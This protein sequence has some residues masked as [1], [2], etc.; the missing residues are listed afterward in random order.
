MYCHNHH[1]ILDMTCNDNEVI[2]L[3]N[4]MICKYCN[5]SHN[6]WAEYAY[7]ILLLL[8]YYFLDTVVQAMSH[9]GT[10]FGFETRGP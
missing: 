4:A 8:L 5:S 10:T 6:K 3:V 1:D 2:N 9:L 7:V